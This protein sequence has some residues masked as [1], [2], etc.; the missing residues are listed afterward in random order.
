MPRKG[1]KKNTCTPKK[2]KKS[3]I[4]NGELASITCS[5]E[6]VSTL[7]ASTRKSLCELFNMSFAQGAVP[8]QWQQADI[9]LYTKKVRR[10]IERTIDQCHLRLL[11]ARYVR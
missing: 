11:L 3:V 1:H 5:P 6:E 4:N 8:D 9:V 2:P 7:F 10:I